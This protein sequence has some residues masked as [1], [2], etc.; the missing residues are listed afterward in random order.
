MAMS[1]SHPG[2][3]VTL[4]AIWFFLGSLGGLIISNQRLAYNHEQADRLLYSLSSVSTLNHP[5][6]LA[7]NS[8]PN[9]NIDAPS[10]NRGDPV[11]LPSH[12]PPSNVIPN[13]DPGAACVPQPCK[14]QTRRTGVLSA[15]LAEFLHTKPTHH[16]TVISVK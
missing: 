8:S 16:I 4:W 1:L 2:K 15:F 13:T 6:L 5:V 11:L 10:L 14:Q 9:I 3:S 12:P 7:M